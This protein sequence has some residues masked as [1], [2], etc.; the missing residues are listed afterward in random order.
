MKKSVLFSAVGVLSVSA[1]ITIGWGEVGTQTGPP[2]SQA[3]P[4]VLSNA[5]FGKIVSGDFTGDRKVDA[6]VMNGSQPLLLV[7]PEVHTTSIKAGG[8]ANDIA[9]LSGVVPGKAL[10]LA[11]SS[12]GLTSHERD[13]VNHVW[14]P[15]TISGSSPWLGALRVAVGALSTAGHQDIAG[16][17]ANGHDVLTLY[18][19]GGQYTAGTTFSAIGQNV[20]GLFLLNWR[21]VEAQD[22]ANTD[23]IALFSNY[24]V[25][26]YEPN[27]TLV[28]SQPWTWPLLGTVIDDQGTPL[29]RLAMISP[30]SGIDKFYV[31]GSVKS[32]GPFNLGTACAVSMASGDADEDG[33]SDVFVVVNNENKV[34]KYTSSSGDTITFHSPPVKY[35]YGPQN[36]DP[37]H[38]FSTPAIADFNGDGR[39]DLLAPVSGWHQGTQIV[40]GMLAFLQIDQPTP[41]PYCTT[42]S[43]GTL[44]QK[45]DGTFDLVF[46]ITVPTNHLLAVP[47]NSNAKVK[48]S[49][50][51]WHSANLNA[52][53][54]LDPY[55]ASLLS[56]PDPLPPDGSSI[57]LRLNLPSTYIMHSAP[58]VWPLVIRQVVV[59]NTDPGDVLATGPAYVGLIAGGTTWDIIKEAGDVV[60]RGLITGLGPPTTPEGGVGSGPAVPSP[61]DDEE[62]RDGDPRR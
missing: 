45:A 41:N 18:E 40:Q 58:D 13:S 26:V 6:V 56:L 51:L 25:E 55:S 57:E 24:G 61:D 60:I 15:T 9:V 62:P 1:A 59:T 20:Y 27:G 23:E 16:I 4:T 42:L 49:V 47:P 43:D 11:V 35:A 7:T 48:F 54:D 5:Q 38:N 30:V 17:A 29:Q 36:R 12:T 33:D 39:V 8:P 44:I 34:K 3:Y 19:T 21:D 31:F 53:T 50:M 2:L 22:T 52:R 10:L 28:G 46:Y 14:N 37:I 32:E